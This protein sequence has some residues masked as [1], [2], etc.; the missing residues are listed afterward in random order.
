MFLLLQLFYD[1]IKYILYVYVYE[2]VYIPFIA[3]Q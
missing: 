2:Y 1:N 3:T